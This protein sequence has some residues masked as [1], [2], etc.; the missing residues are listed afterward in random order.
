MNSD[1][2]LIFRGW[3]EKETTKTRVTSKVG[4]KSRR[5]RVDWEPKEKS[6]S[7]RRVSSTVCLYC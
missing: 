6:V 4:G 7:R 2:L 3:V 1:E 5:G